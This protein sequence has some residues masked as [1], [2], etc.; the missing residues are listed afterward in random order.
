MEVIEGRLEG[1]FE[2]G[3]EGVVW[4]IYKDG[5][6]PGNYNALESIEA[7]DHLTVFNEDGS[8]AWEGEIDPDY[9]VGYTTYPRNPE[10]GQQAA[11]G[12][13]VH[14][15]QKG[16]Q[17]DDWAKFFIQSKATF[18]GLRAKL[19]KNEYSEEHTR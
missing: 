5:Y 11:L 6:N 9:E 8:I 12:C 1:F 16:F 15:I 13:W 14:W 17:P 19:V 10:Y 7:G 2:T 18:E 3:T 4:M